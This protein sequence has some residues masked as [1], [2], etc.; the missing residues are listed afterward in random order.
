MKASKR[1]EHLWVGI[2]GKAS[3]YHALKEAISIARW[4]H[5][6]VTAIAVAPLYEGDLSLT[7]VGSVQKNLY[8]DI[9]TSL[10]CAL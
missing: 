2:N 7:G 10:G 9:E 4:L 1:P 8:K 3:G 5:A 6:G